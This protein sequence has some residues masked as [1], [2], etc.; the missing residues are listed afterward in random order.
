MTVRSFLAI[1]EV[2]TRSLTPGVGEERPITWAHVSEL[3]D[4][5][6]WLGHGALVMTTGLPIP[7]DA[8]GQIAYFDGMYRAGIAAVAIGARMSAPPLTAEAL[9]HAT[10]LGFP[11][12]E[13][14]YETP[15]IL[16]ATAVAEAS[17]R[18]RAHRIRLTEQMYAVLREHADT[19]T[20][21]PLLAAI[22]ELLG[23]ELDL[24]P[25]GDRPGAEPGRIDALGGLAYETPLLT[26]GSP[27][28]RFTFA[29]PNAPDPSL[30]QHA[31]GILASALSVRSAARRNEWLYGSILLGNILDAS[32]PWEFATRYLQARGFEE[33]LLM[34]VAPPGETAGHLETAQLAFADAGVPALATVRDEELILLT[35]SHDSAS[36]VLDQLAPALGQIG[37]SAPF[38]GL[39]S[40]SGAHRQ[41]VIARSQAGNREGAISRFGSSAEASLF[42]PRDPEQLRAIADQV[43]GPLRAYERRRG[44][45]LVQTLRV[46]LEENRS[47]V[48]ASERLFI[49]RQTLV[50]RIARVETVLSRDL[51]SM[52]D[53]AECW[54]AVRAAIQT[55][56][57]DD[58][59]PRTNV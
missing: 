19:K 46:F 39:G 21:A 4:P 12:L 9:A 44:T 48:R 24:R 2:T 20:A 50:A 35:P 27:T 40:A 22:G 32:V 18:A 31:A 1:P 55:G 26:L 47:W 16:L 25:H 15:F 13:T 56:E 34:S 52:E 42:L 23:A 54:L 5:G 43:L 49:H 36:R 3:E 8:A 57:I 28:L 53:A 33:P 11:V 17:E 37:V 7:A 45:P 14:A 51:N 58:E 6:R 30:M 38:A 59:G 41:A 10:E 29:D